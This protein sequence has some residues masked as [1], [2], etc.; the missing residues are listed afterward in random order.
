MTP[1]YPLRFHPLLRHY[2]WGGEKLRTLLGKSFD[3]HATCAESWEICDR[4]ADQSVV[5]A[6]PLAGTTLGELVITRGAELLGRHAPQPRFPLLFKFLDARLKLS[7]QV[8]PDDERASQLTPPDLGKTEAWVVMDAE[9]DGLI[10]AGLKRGFDRAALAR[11]I[12]R[13]TCELC[14]HSFVPRAGDC[15]F[16]PAGVVHALG[17]GLLVAEIQQSSDT[18]WRLFDWNRLGPDGRP[19]ALHIA[20]ALDAID[21]AAG[22]VSPVHPAATEKSA[23][24]RLVECDPFVLD[25]W[26]LSERY[27]L[28]D[29]DRC[30]IL[31]VVEGAVEVSDDAAQVPLKL[32]ET[33][34]LPAR[35]AATSMIPRPSAIVLDAFLP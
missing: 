17:G 35:R 3:D 30:H 16:L 8:H 4:G 28:R 32:G 14:L 18:T 2:M 31:A 22:P 23:V 19:R 15:I 13:G 11:E 24:E 7:V 29:D 9:P 10:Y 25:R 34:L 5:A 1:L 27:E 33:M 6:G 12:A 21:Y 26:R 20:E